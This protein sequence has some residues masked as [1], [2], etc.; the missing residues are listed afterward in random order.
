MNIPEQFSLKDKVA[1]I[2]GSSA[3]IG[4]A[5]AHGMAQ[6]GAHV[7]VSSRKQD[8]VDAVVGELREEGLSAFGIPAHVGKP[9]DLDK[10]VHDTVHW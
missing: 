5:I 3:G 7:V 1:I 6:A 8:A 10:L 4:K 2:T 9:E